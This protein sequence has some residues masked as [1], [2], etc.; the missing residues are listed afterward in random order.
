MRP[1][2]I[3][4]SSEQWLKTP[5]LSQFGLSDP[6]ID[7]TASEA[8]EALAKRFRVEWL[9]DDHAMVSPTALAQRWDFIE[10][11]VNSA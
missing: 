3:V 11:M 4:A 7:E 1:L 10:S 9:D 6:Y 2:D 5:C 8:A